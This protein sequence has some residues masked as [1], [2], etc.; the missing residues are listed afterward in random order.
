MNPITSDDYFV[1]C[2]KHGNPIDDYL[3]IDAHAHLGKI[4]GFSIP[5]TSLETIVAGMDRIGIDI[6]CVSSFPAAF[7]KAKIGNDVILDVVSRYPTRFFGYMCADIGYPERILPEL[8]RCLDA[9]LRG[10]KVVSGGLINGLPYNH[11]N[12]EK[13]FAFADHHKLPVLAHTWTYEHEIKE[14]QSMFEKYKNAKFILAH[15][16]NQDIDK[17]IQVAQRYENVYLELCF[18][19]CPRGVIEYFVDCGLVD[20]VIWGSDSIFHNAINQ[21]GRVLFAKI[22][23]EDKIKILGINVKRVLNLSCDE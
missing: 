5:D 11:P 6:S 12:Y 13:V 19:A 9:G 18:S 10:I 3:V 17:Y 7:G 2:V 4:L 22:S 21:L 20:K 16:G 14:L 1:D 23:V 15:A 8:E